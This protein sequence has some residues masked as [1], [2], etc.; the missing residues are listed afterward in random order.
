MKSMTPVKHRDV[1]F[2][3]LRALVIQAPDAALIGRLGEL[4]L[5]VQPGGVDPVSR[6]D[7]FEP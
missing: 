6:P 7:E 5:D 3:G 1:R 2:G 4:G